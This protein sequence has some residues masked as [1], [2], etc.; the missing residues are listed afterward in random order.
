MP[1]E[2]AAQFRAGGAPRRAVTG[3]PYA[4]LDPLARDRR[5]RARARHSTLFRPAELADN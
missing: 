5:L 4:S 3:D 1:A 2:K